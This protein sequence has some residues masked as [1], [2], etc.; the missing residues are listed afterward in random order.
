M[1]DY[2]NLLC[3]PDKDEIISKLVSGIK[4]KDI[5]DWLKLKYSEKEQSHLRLSGVLL[6]DFIE[7]NLDLYSQLRNDI[8]NTK[9]GKDVNKK[10]SESLINNKTYKERL[11]ELADNELDIKKI[12]KETVFLIRERIEQVWDKVQE[13]PSNL[14]PDYALIKW[15]EILLNSAE[16]FNKI[17]NEAPD[18]VVQHN[19]SLQLVEQH[20]LVLQDAIRA[21]LSE[22]D[23]DIAFLFIE[24]LND[25]LAKLKP[26]EPEKQLSQEK[27]IEQAKLLNSKIA[28]AEVI[29]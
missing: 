28:E 18:Q 5:S 16:K 11:N 15:F 13:N 22:I 23:P 3:H 25:K 2:S 14:K 24:K 19:V 7:N 29:V 8:I 21:T 17:V 10:I 27:R 12:L 6:K 20:T 26:A 4:P 1:A 9:D